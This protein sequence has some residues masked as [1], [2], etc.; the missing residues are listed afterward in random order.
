MKKRKGLSLI[1]LI[2]GILIII[3]LWIVIRRLL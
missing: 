2:I 3:I 1:K